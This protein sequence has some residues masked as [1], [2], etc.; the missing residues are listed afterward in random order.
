MENYELIGSVVAA[1][2]R[3][4]FDPDE[5]G[6]ARYLIDCLTAEQTAA[7]AK[8]ILSDKTLT[9]LI[10]VK[11]PEHFVGDFGLPPESLTNERTTYFRHADCNKSALLVR[12][13]ESFSPISGSLSYRLPSL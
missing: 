2:L 10:D 8:A 13:I 4:R 11:L 9:D 12:L 5:E 7:I 3:N 6:T 1:Y